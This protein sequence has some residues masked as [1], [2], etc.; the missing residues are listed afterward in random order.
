MK[1]EHIYIILCTRASSSK[2]LVA[3]LASWCFTQPEPVCLS[4]FIIVSGGKNSFHQAVTA[5]FVKK[6]K[7]KSKSTRKRLKK[8]AN[9]FL[10]S[11]MIHIFNSMPY[12]NPMPTHPSKMLPRQSSVVL[13]THYFTPFQSELKTNLRAPFKEHQTLTL[14]MWLQMI[15]F[16]FSTLHRQIYLF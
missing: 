16:Q 12:F 11:F 10:L 1:K 7:K 3:G 4:L 15:Y 8:N 13:T 2:L 6:K 5:A 9:K 14:A